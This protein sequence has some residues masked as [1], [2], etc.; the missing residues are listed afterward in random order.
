[1]TQ[2]DSEDVLNIKIMNV[3]GH[4]DL[5]KYLNDTSAEE[6]SAQT[7]ENYNKTDLNK[8]E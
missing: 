1:M 4:V 3:R 6:S 8:K 7:D 5:N 2:Q